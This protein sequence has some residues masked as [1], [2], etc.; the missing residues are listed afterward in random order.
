VP[1]V[2]RSLLRDERSWRRTVFA[3]AA[4]ALVVRLA[5]A[6][7]TGGGNDLKIY[8]AFASL[9]ADGQ[10]PFDPPAGFE[11]PER[12]SDNLPG[13]YLLF[14]GLLRIVDSPDTLRVLF[15]FA[16]AGVVL[17]VGLLYPRPIAWRAA[18]VAFYAFNPLVLGSWTATAEDKTIVFG[19]VAAMLCAL[20]L[21]R[22]AASWGAAAVV[23]VL[24]G[25]S[26]FF[27]PFLAWETWRERGLRV[28]ALCVAGF[29][30]V[31]L[32]GHLPW[33]PD[34]FGVYEQRNEH[35]DAREPGH[36]AF[37]QL[38]DRAGLYD[39]ALVKVGVPLL[40]VATFAA[41]VVRWIDV[42]EG[43]VL[44]SLATLVLQPDHAYTRALLAALPFLLVIALTPRRWAVLWAVSSV[45]A[46][47][48]YF[49][50]ERDGLGGYG[51][52]AHVIVANVFLVLVLAYWARDKWAARRAEAP[53]M[54]ASPARA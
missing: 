45:A 49:Q 29:G 52:L 48:V 4:L 27:A 36:A 34:A 2:L 16:D 12:L 51:S 18:F 3:V 7:V 22:F 13:E 38:L 28:A 24:K 5:I 6:A 14:A 17:L 54:T 39:P 9:A 47:G 20:E 8:Y 33:F 40:L 42:R 46:V 25:L 19:L 50:Q 44:A 26:L 11:F 1:D 15:A 10:N 23:G 30:A 41:Y 43:I 37:T 31:M 53:G 35:I 21:R 32:L